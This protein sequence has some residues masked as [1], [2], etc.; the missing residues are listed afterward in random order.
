MLG[1][2]DELVAA[3]ARDRVLGPQR[4]GDAVGGAAQHLVAARVAEAV[5]D[6]LEAVEVEEQ[7]GQRGV[8]ALQPADRVVEAVEEQHAVGQAGQRVVQRLV[9]QQLL[10]ALAD[11]ELADL[12]AERRGEARQVVVEPLRARAGELEQAERVGAAQRPG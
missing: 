8:L 6:R 10:G 3:E 2:H 1:E 11:E 12:R 4:G 9:E 7:H 5:V